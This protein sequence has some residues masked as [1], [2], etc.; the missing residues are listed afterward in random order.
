MS[1]YEKK[2]WVNNET[3][4]N[5]TNMNHIEEGIYT[6]SVEIEELKNDKQ[7]INYEALT[8]AELKALKDNN[9]L[10]PNKAYRITDYVTKVN[11]KIN[12][13]SDLARSMEHPFDIFVLATSTN[14]FSEEAFACLH[15]GDTYFVNSDLSSW[16]L[17]YCFE[18]D[19][20]RFEWADTINGKGVIYRMID[21][22]DNDIPYDFKNVQFK[23]FKITG[24][25][26]TRQEELIDKY[27][28]FSGSY[29]VTFDANDFK[30]YYT[31]TDDTQ[32]ESND[33]SIL[34]VYDH[35]YDNC[36][37]AKQVCI[38]EYL[39]D[40]PNYRYRQ[41]LNDIVLASPSII[42]DIKM[43]EGST[44]NTII[45][46]KDLTYNYFGAMCRK[47]IMYGEITHNKSDECMENNTIGSGVRDF[48][49]FHWNRV[50]RHFTRNIVISAQATNFATDSVSDNKFPNLMD[51][52]DFNGWVQRNDFS[53]L[54]KA[55][56]IKLHK[57]T[58]CTLS[59]SSSWVYCDFLAL[60]SC[61]I[62]I[63]T[64]FGSKV[65]F[66]QKVTLTKNSGDTV[67]LINIDIS[68]II[69]STTINLSDLLSYNLSGTRCHKELNCVKTNNGSGNRFEYTYDYV[70]DGVK[71]VLGAYSEDNGV[72]WLPLAQ[73]QEVYN[74]LEITSED[75]T[76]EDDKIVFN[77]D[78]AQEIMSMN[79]RLRV[80][81]SVVDPRLEQ[82]E[83]IAVFTPRG[84]IDYSLPEGT[85]VYEYS[86]TNW[87]LDTYRTTY[88]EFLWDETTEK[89]YVYA[90]NIT[91]YEDHIVGFSTESTGGVEL[92]S[93]IDM[94]TSRINTLRIN[95]LDTISF[96]TNP[97][98]EFNANENNE[99]ESIAFKEDGSTANFTYTIP[100]GGGKLYRHSIKVANINRNSWC[101][102]TL[103][104]SSGTPFTTSTL[105]NYLIN[106]YGD[107][108]NRF[109][110]A[111][112]DDDIIPM[113]AYV[114]VDRISTNGY[115][116]PSSQKYVY[117]FFYVVS[118]TVTEV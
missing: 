27:I 21:E 95:D 60:E 89:L 83:F 112:S 54:N 48:E 11:G 28:G 30:W 17:W 35:S 32:V 103:D 42:V 36:R 8:Y 117:S 111:L 43:R 118:D 31:L 100:Q 82:G 108:A 37:Y 59:G 55:Q 62:N 29:A 25:T 96:D 45:G 41:A 14:T 79:K 50:G 52:C 109:N 65:D 66:L 16:K 39:A 97:S 51:A 88:V 7:E 101:Y 63:D 72:T 93:N 1:T 33:L 116:I 12:N 92:T 57:V 105:F 13:V 102:L 68:T 20:D 94:R 49:A 78:V 113:S 87:L 61:N 10:T 115:S 91:K 76:I 24:T 44:K 104:T 69:G 86:T 56:G 34:S 67:N 70:E 80:D 47:N 26:D 53:G 58:S 2:T 22:F 9:E 81:A 90:N 75:I 73:D 23:R 74:T 64:F 6:N 98:L 15:E 85:I 107:Q 46:N 110:I 99:L 19:T 40:E 18:N 4:V 71:S 38:G 3:K 5:A 84:V 77:S 106:V 114:M